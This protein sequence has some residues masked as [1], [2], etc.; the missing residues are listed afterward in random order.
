MR[1]AANP[2]RRPG[3]AA[4]ESE[5]LGSSR[6]AEATALEPGPADDLDFGLPDDFQ[7]ASPSRA[8]DLSAAFG[9]PALP[10]PTDGLA[11]ARLDARDTPA[12]DQSGLPAGR[13]RQLNDRRAGIRPTAKSIPL[14]RRLSTSPGETRESPFGTSPF[15]NGSAN[16]FLGRSFDSDDGFPSRS[17]RAFSPKMN[18][19]RPEEEL[20]ALE[21]H[22]SDDDDLPAFLP[23]LLHSEILTPDER[24]RQRSRQDT[25]RARDGGLS[26]SVPTERLVPSRARLPPPS[27]LFA[28]STKPL[29]DARPLAGATSP[30]PSHRH[31]YPGSSVDSAS[32]FIES[33]SSAP[34]LSPP[35]ALPQDL[36]PHVPGGS[37]PQGL[38]AQPSRRP[39]GQLTVSLPQC[40][41]PVEASPSAGDR[42]WHE[43]TGRG[44]RR[45]G[46]RARD[47]PG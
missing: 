30:G 26:Q 39:S 34:A 45:C 1:D 46:S 9:R 27:V 40:R 4:A 11:F 12:H 2:A 13:A 43:S 20:D 6:L 25:I 5:V 19:S 38:S 44:L 32:T 21:P 8:N 36:A 18:A 29:A 47:W 7:P 3:Q 24:K 41:R 14:D 10:G 16:V 42:D 23:S 33:G 17:P 37:L 15:G 22:H 31:P 28:S 35:L